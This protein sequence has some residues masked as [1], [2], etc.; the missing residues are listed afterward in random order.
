VSDA[1]AQREERVTAAILD[2]YRAR[3]RGR[4]TTL[5]AARMDDV[6]GAGRRDPDDRACECRR[7]KL[8]Y[9]AL[10]DGGN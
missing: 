9:I 5:S 3:L 1:G 6:C 4:I 2:G 8:S 7:E 10:G